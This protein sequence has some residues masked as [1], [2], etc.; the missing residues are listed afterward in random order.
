MGRGG[1]HTDCLLRCADRVRSGQTGF[2]SWIRANLA[3]ER[4][5]GPWDVG[6]GLV[7]ARC[8]VL[9]SQLHRDHTKMMARHRFDCRRHQLQ[10]AETSALLSALQLTTLISYAI[11][12]GAPLG[13]A[14]TDLARSSREKEPQSVTL[15]GARVCIVPRTPQVRRPC[16]LPWTAIIIIQVSAPNKAQRS[17]GHE[18]A[19][20]GRHSRNNWRHQSRSGIPLSRTSSLPQ[21]NEALVL[22]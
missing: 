11:L 14:S 3:P 8:L 6:F 4:R 13:P 1:G 22:W 16:N 12:P 2:N 20:E 19:G 9:I 10:V 21:R 15:R 7:W 17:T 5:V 18:R